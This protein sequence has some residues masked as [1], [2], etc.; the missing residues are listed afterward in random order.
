MAIFR[1]FLS[2]HHRLVVFG[3]PVKLINMLATGIGRAVAIQ[4]Q[5]ITAILQLRRNHSSIST[6]FSNSKVG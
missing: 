1:L 2:F 4:K 3:C 6:R 5:K